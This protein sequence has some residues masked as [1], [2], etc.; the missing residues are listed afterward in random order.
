MSVE[1]PSED[2]RTRPK[3]RRTVAKKSPNLRQAATKKK[4]AAPHLEHDFEFTLDRNWRIVTITPMAAEWA[5]AQAADL[6]GRDTRE[7]WSPP[8]QSVVDAVEAA[9]SR[10]A[11]SSLAQ[12]SLLVP[13]RWLKA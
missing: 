11:T 6:L 8:P 13:G 5:G 9:L 4:R 3:R 7:I 2:A 10:G 12:P 1:L